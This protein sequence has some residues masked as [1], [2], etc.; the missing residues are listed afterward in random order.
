RNNYFHNNDI[1]ISLDGTVVDSVTT[2]NL[3][4]GNRLEANAKYGIFV[5]EAPQNQIRANTI[6]GNLSSGIDLRKAAQNQL[7]ANTLTGNGGHGVTLS[8]SAQQNFLLGN[9][10]QNN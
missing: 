5:R 9:I 2:R 10:I 1:G 7:E 6:T 4:E 3:V 8:D